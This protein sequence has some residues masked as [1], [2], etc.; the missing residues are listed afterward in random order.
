MDCLVDKG[1]YTENDRRVVYR[2]YMPA[3][4]KDMITAKYFIYADEEH[5]ILLYTTLVYLG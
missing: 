5:A 2:L 3:D 1:L 4:F